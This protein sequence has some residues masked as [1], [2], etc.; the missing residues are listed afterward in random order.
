MKKLLIP[1]ALLVIGVWLI[2]GSFLTGGKGDDRLDI[3]I[4]STPLIMP[5][6]HKV[7]ANPEAL[8]GQY[9]LFKA[10]ITNTGTKPLENVVIKYEVPGYI[11]WTDLSTAGRVIPGQ[12]IV[13]VCYPVFD[14][15]ITEKTTESMERVNILVEWD[16]AERKDILEET[17]SF[18]MLNRNDFAY[19]NLPA[20][21]ISGWA[22]MYS[23]NDL[24]ACFV[25]PHDPVVKYY[26]QLVQQKVLK[27][28][29]AAIS[30]SPEQ[31]V[32]FLLGLYEATRMSK[33][34]YSG[35]KGI[36]STLE[37]V[38]TLI[39]HIRLPREVITGNTGLCIELS[40]LYASALSS[41]GLNPVIFLIPGHAYPGFHMQ[42]QY[43]VIEPTGIGGEG[44]GGIQTAEEAFQSGM[45]QLEEF[46]QAS[47]MGDPRYTFI[48]IHALNARGVVSMNLEDNEF[49]RKKVD[50]IALNF[51]D[52]PA[53]TQLAGGGRQP[54]PTPPTPSNRFPGP[55]SFIIP[56]GWQTFH[57]PSPQFPLLIAQVVSPDQMASIS[58]Y[59]IPSSNPQEALS[60]LSQYFLQMGLQL[61]YSLSG[62]SAQGTS[63]NYAGTFQWV[64][65]IAPTHEG[66]RFV[67]VGADSRMYNQYASEIKNVF[68]SIK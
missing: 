1:M 4:I 58:V 64:G 43:F 44:L 49:M 10:K 17:F 60:L 7:Y 15:R 12:S 46:L 59:N 24:I 23:N 56:A 35:T 32:R 57:Q 16:G 47:R 27:G 51:T 41:A 20:R 42:G 8:D 66:C 2:A 68:N 9:H 65:K 31:G 25:T 33:M 19:S 48:D 55:L 11:S 28:E 67:A 13:A 30:R 62:N 50:E 45:K 22:D 39:Q 29:S 6:V 40:V 26:T 37:D 54:A 34:V 14:D 18:K 63:S 53:R 36:P 5:A 3:E 52:R 38:Q 21:E 61:D